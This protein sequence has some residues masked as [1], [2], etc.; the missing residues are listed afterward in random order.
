MAPA[1][2]ETLTA[3]RKAAPR[4]AGRDVSA[5]Q[6]FLRASEPI[7]GAYTA[8]LDASTR[9]QALRTGQRAASALA[10]GPQQDKG[11]W[12]VDT[13][14]RDIGRLPE[15]PVAR[16]LQLAELPGGTVWMPTPAQ[17]DQAAADYFAA[18]AEKRAGRLAGVPD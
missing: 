17:Q 3:V 11:D 9:Y 1:L 7:R 5:A 4:L 12:F 16:L 6:S 15:H 18:G 8:V 13:R 2:R 14:V 10:G